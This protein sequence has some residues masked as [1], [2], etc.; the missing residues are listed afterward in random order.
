MAQVLASVVL[1]VWVV[2][3]PGPVEWQVVAVL[4]QRF[5]V[6][7]VERVPQQHPALQPDQ[8]ELGRYLA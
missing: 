4:V 1:V 8:A 5:V 6:L 2:V 7:V 3:T